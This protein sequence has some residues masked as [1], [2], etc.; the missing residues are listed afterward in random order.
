MRREAAKRFRERV[1]TQRPAVP[2]DRR[3]ASD[4]YTTGNDFRDQ[5]EARRDLDS[6]RIGYEL[7][8]CACPPKPGD[9]S[10]GRRA[11]CGTQNIDCPEANRLGGVSQWWKREALLPRGN[12]VC[13]RFVDE[14][15]KPNS[16]PYH[17]LPVIRGTDEAHVVRA[18][19]VTFG[20]EPVNQSRFP[21]AGIPRESNAALRGVDRTGVKWKHAIPISNCGETGSEQKPDDG[22]LGGLSI[23]SDQNLVRAGNEKLTDAGEVEREVPVVRGPVTTENQFL[24][25]DNPDAHQSKLR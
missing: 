6:I 14:P 9:F 10:A 15:E 19:R 18:D 23:G 5:T 3:G 25:V 22:A 1:E 21:G 8:G 2:I 4:I 16:R 17:D 20:N 13:C 7:L 11:G 12:A 24:D